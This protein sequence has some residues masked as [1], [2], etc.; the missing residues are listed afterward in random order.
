MIKYKRNERITAILNILLEKP[1]QIISYNYL[2]E[3][4]NAAKSTISEDIMILKEIVKKLS[5]GEIET[6]IGA[7][8][9]VR[10]LIKLQKN[11]IEDILNDLSIKLSEG[12]RI[13]PG[14]FIY[15]TDILYL[16][17]I[18]NNIGKIFAS[19]FIE[20]KID[21][22]VTVEMKGI[23][24]ALMTAKYLNVPLVIIR[25]NTKVTEGPTVSINYLSGSTKKINTMSLSRKAMKEN[26]KVLV[27]D[28]FMKAGGTAKGIE[29]MMKEFKSEVVATGVLIATE[30]PSKKLVR[31]YFSLLTLKDIDTENNKI[32]I[33]PSKEFLSS[34]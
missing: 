1:N 30:N 3:K 29:D 11:N 22:V 33:E 7:A 15:M 6:T 18:V 13:I 25:N 16:P 34:E 20:R 12:N 32:I 31:N 17:N 9:G 4:F 5:I 21:Y 24:L 23:P 28:D 10:L 14:G 26:S 27:I 19:K 8:G 2:S